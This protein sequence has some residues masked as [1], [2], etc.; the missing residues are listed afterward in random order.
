MPAVTI[1]NL[2]DETHRALKVRAA[3]HGRSTE[4]EM[5]D[6]LEAAVRPAERLRLG[7]A[8][9]ALSRKAGLTNA[10]FEALEQAR[11]K[12]TATPMSFE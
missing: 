7:S 10:D 5:R 6:I 11:D 1:R 12:T 3:Q 2:S 8:L 9:S 4:A